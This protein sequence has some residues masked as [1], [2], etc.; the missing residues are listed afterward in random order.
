LPFFEKQPET[1]SRRDIGLPINDRATDIRGMRIH[2]CG[3]A[4]IV[5]D[6]L[7]GQP[8]AQASSP[9]LPRPPADRVRSITEKTSFRDA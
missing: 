9:E 2:L 4:C 8:A 6:E 1:D 7:A 3:D 5:D